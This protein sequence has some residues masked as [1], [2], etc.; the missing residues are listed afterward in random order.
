MVTKHVRATQGLLVVAVTAA[1][2]VGTMY[3]L[4]E[5]DGAPPR[6]PEPAPF[7]PADDGSKLR[8]DL[9]RSSPEKM[10]LTP[11]RGVWGVLM[12][13]SYA[14]GV[15]TVVALTDGTASMYIS[16]GGALTGGKAFAPARTAAQMLCE[17]A[18]DS[19]DKTLPAKDF[20]PPAKGRV[21][22]YVLA[23]GGVR[24]LERDILPSRDAGPDPAAPLVEAG[25]ALLAA[26]KEA[27]SKG[28]IR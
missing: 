25:D 26:L 10:G 7:A 11:V 3:L 5:S 27:T 28:Y 16:T 24:A 9:L 20:A 2:V 22:F 18:A 6:Q 19:L 1:L 15:A 23:K 12:E 14:K 21:R 8:D 13:R 17:Q 4:Q